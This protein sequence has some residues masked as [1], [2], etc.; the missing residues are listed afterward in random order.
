MTESPQSH[1]FVYPDSVN[2]HPPTIG[3]FPHNY[4]LKEMV[5]LWNAQFD[6]FKN[7]EYLDA[8]NSSINNLILIKGN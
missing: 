1:I 4:E 7:K 6:M 8:L 3:K 2:I 5:N